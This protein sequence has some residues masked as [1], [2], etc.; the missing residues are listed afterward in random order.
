MKVSLL[1]NPS[2]LDK[3]FPPGWPVP[4]RIWD[5]EVGTESMQ[6][7]FEVYDM[8]AE[9][10]FDWLAVSEHHYFPSLLGPNPNLIAAVLANRYPQVGI[11]VLGAVLPQV[12]PIRVAEEY[13]TLDA[14]SGGR[15]LAGMFRGLPNEFIAYGTNP[16]QA[17]EMFDEAFE[18]ILRA[19]TEPEPFWWEGR[20][21]RFPVVSLWPRPVQQ[22]YP[23]IVV[24]GTSAQSAAFAG[25]HRLKLGL[26]FIIGAERAAEMVRIYRE[27]AAEAGWEPSPDDILYRARVYVADSDAQA[28]A[29]SREFELGDFMG[30]IAPPPER[31]GAWGAIMAEAATGHGGSRPPGRGTMPEYYGNPDTVAAA[32]RAESERIG[33]GVLDFSFD[34]FH[35]P[36]GKALRSLE[37]FGREVLPQLR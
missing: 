11:A 26:I 18:L 37:L 21:Y 28:E 7:I 17:R 31:R 20:Y 34:A 25:R 3:R 33:Y 6:R 32:L 27:A 30:P 14:L 19:W 8:A 4:P 35:L 16:S 13:A 36:H 24:S 22:P 9:L 2:Y 23:P 1:A 5:P 29:D 10:G 12:N 15:L